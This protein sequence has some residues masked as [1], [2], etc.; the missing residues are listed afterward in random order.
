MTDKERPDFEGAFDPTS[1]HEP[2]RPPS[3]LRTLI[4]APIALIVG[5]VRRPLALIITIIVI[6]FLH[7]AITGSFSRKS[8]RGTWKGLEIRRIK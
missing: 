1:R 7:L 2:Y 3:R 8:E 5:I 6:L 4:N